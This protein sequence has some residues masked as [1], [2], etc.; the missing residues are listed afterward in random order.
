MN[1]AIFAMTV[2][3]V[4]VGGLVL[5]RHDERGRV[6]VTQLSRQ[7]IVERLDGKDARVSVQEVLIEPGERA[8]APGG[9]V[10]QDPLVGR[11]PGVDEQR[12]PGG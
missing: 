2:C 8:D 4:G 6:K 1:R 10:D 12:L 11:E 9:A 7:E 3:V 5:A